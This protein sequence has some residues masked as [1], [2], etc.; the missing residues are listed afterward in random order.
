[1][2]PDTIKALIQKYQGEIEFRQEM[3]R[4]LEADL[5]SIGASGNTNRPA[6]SEQGTV[7]QLKDRRVG[8]PLSDIREYQFFNKSQPEAAEM[9][10]E[11]VGHPLNISAIVEGLEKGSI[12]VGGKT[13]AERRQNLAT[14]LA[15]SGRFGR[16]ARGT[17]GLPSW[18]NIEPVERTRAGGKNGGEAEEA[19]GARGDAGA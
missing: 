7:K 19:R 16:A 9:L 11:S 12:K 4:H 14:V 13:A 17:W 8:D 5:A 1:M 10:L 15:R 6:G 3:I 18:P 2:D